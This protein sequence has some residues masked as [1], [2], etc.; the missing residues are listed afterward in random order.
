MGRLLGPGASAKPRGTA[1]PPRLKKKKNGV[2]QNHCPY[3]HYGIVMFARLWL[4]TVSS[5][6]AH[7]CVII[8]A[9]TVL[10]HVSR[11]LAV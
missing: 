1:L 3:H 4:L 11:S 8:I 6:I 5:T 2:D 10:S 7:P 9:S